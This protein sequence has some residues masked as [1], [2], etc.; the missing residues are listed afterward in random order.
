M[1]KG[2][3]VDPRNQQALEADEYVK[4]PTSKTMGRTQQIA[5]AKLA[6]LYRAV[7]ELKGGNDEALTKAF[8]SSDE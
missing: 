4:T 5:D 8:E 2:K 1:T 3:A 7:L 6:A